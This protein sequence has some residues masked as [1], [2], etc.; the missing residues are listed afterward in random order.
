MNYKSNIFKNLDK[1]LEL[2][3]NWDGYNGVKINPTIVKKVKEIL[4]LHPYLFN[5]DWWVV[6]MS[7]GHVQL[8]AD[9]KILDV[10]LE[11]TEVGIDCLIYYTK[12]HYH[13][14]HIPYDDLNKLEALFKKRQWIHNEDY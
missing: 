2:P 12:S 14:E 11:F 10:E 7:D 4:E 9:N 8:E 3:R 5:L 1:L 6:P 13:T